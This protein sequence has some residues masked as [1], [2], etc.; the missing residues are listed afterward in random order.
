MHVLL[1]VHPPEVD[2]HTANNCT[3]ARHE[4]VAGA[5]QIAMKNTT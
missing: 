5:R 1:V 3:E 4:V 2:V